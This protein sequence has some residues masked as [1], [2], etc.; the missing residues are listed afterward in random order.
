V[1]TQDFLN[2]F[3]LDKDFHQLVDSLARHYSLSV[4]S[5]LAKE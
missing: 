3:K 5:N 2:T 1:Q 4:L